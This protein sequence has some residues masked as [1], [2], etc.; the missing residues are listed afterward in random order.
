MDIQKARS[1]FPYLK[2]GKVYFGHASTAPLST[3]V[4]DRLKDYIHVR[5]ETKI[6]DYTSVLKSMENVKNGLA[7]MINSTPDRIAFTDNT[8][9]GINM[10]A[11]SVVWK[12]NDRVILN[13]IES[14]SYTHLTLP[15]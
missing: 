2:T 5:S 13:D 15:T 4:V 14:V 1:L 6:D 9:N 12:Q 7:E 11:Q 10:L 8:N 3:Y